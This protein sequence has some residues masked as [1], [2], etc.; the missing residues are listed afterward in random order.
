MLTVHHISKV[1][2]IETVLDDVSFSIQPGERFG[3]VGPNGCGKTTLLRIIAGEEKPER[4][5]VQLMPASLRVGYLPQGFHIP[6][7]ETIES[8]ITRQEGDLPRLTHRLE[9]VAACLA[10]DPQRAGLQQEYDSLLASLESAEE[11]VRQAPGILAGLGLDRVPLTTPAAILSGGQKT[12]LGLAGVLLSMPRLLLLD[13]PTNHLDIAMLEWLEGWLNTFPYAV[14]VVS[15]DRAFLDRTV[16][17][18]LEISPH[19]HGLKYYPGNY[20]DFVAQKQSET[21][22]QWQEYHDQ[23]DQV[24]RLERAARHMRGLAQ[25]RKGGKADSGDKFARG[26]FA[27]RSLGTIGRARS[28]EQRIEHI[29]TEERVDKPARSWEMKLEFADVPSSGR[30]VLVLEDLTVGY[31]GPPLLEHL[32]LTLRYGERLALI[33]PNGSGKTSL[34]RTITGQIAPQGGRCRLGSNVHIGLMAQEQENLRP[35]ENALQS[36]LRLVSQNETEARSFLSKYLFKGDDVFVPVKSLSYGER[37]RLSLACLVAENSN[38]LLLDEPVNHLDIP[39]RARFEEALEGFQGTILAVVHD[40]YFIQNFATQIW[41]ISERSIRVW[42][43]GQ[44]AR[45]T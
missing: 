13:E 33:G 32:N 27:N 28:I 11:C 44:G 25:F 5:S 10:V 30:D 21:E 39:A 43:T 40:R 1:F 45:T 20:S 36:I 38:F 31:G 22:K 23:Q 9:E 17:G 8:F 24:A 2:G 41:E 19:T 14:L 37:A 4:G 12:R 18:I 42:D 6:E 3:L 7:G 26:F 16:T 35:E 34:L 15:H 29:L